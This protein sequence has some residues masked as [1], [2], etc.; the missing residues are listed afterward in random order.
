[1][2]IVYCTDTVCYPGGIQ[3]VTM[4]KANA[5]AKVSGNEVWIVVTDHIKP[6]LLSLD[7]VHLVNLEVNYYSDDWKGYWYVVKGVFHKRKLHRQ[8]LQNVLNE[9]EPDIVIST[10]TS[11]KYFLPSL[12][13]KSHP[14]FIREMHFVKNYRSLS[15]NNL[16]DKISAVFSELYDYCFMIK[17]YDKIVTLTHED[18]ESN[19]R[20]GEDVVVIPNPMTKEV[21]MRSDCSICKAVSAGRLVPQKNFSSLINVWKRVAECHPDWI[22]EIW[23]SGGQEKLLRELI[24]AAGLEKKILLK[25]YTPEIHTKMA[26]A[27]MFLLTSHYEG[28]GLVLLEAMS[29]GLPVISYQCPTG[30]RDLIADGENGFLIQPNDEDGFAEKVCMLMADQNLRVKMG[31]NALRTSKNYRMEKIIGMWMDLFYSL[32]N[33]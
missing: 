26:A 22:L 29:V 1:M 5:L 11:E 16:R 30:P 17:K 31:A 2:K 25:G 14:S 24:G 3:M 19:W 21:I 32:R 13:V 20:K 6:P 23:G 8:R 15:A 33:R 9:I 18:R 10:G 7:D 28:F 4:A 27:S 12:K